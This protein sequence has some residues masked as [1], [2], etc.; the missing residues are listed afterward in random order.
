VSFFVFNASLYMVNDVVSML[1][2]TGS[3]HD[4]AAAAEARGV[5]LTRNTA[6]RVLF[7]ADL[8]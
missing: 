7:L 4:N 3:A 5:K 8:A 6:E 1:L 2:M